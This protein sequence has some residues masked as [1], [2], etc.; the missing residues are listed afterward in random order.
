MLAGLVGP[1][2]VVMVGILAEDRSKVLFAVDEY[3]V[4]ALG[5]CCAY[6]SLGATVRAWGPRRGLDRRQALAC[7]DL[8]EGAGELGVAVPDEEAEGADRSPIFMSKLRA[9]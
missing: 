9:C 2:P 3:P 8:V 7:E 6:P 4:A 1:V 5:S